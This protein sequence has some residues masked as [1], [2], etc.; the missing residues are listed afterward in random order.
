LSS[1]VLAIVARHDPAR[2]TE[3][4]RRRAKTELPFDA[5][6]V[7]EGAP[8]LFDT[9]VYIDQL[10]GDLP[11]AIVSLISS[12]IIFHATP[13]LAE[14]A[15]TVGALNPTDERTNHTLLPILET[16]ERIPLQR[17]ISPQNETWLE[18]ALIAGILA[19][20]QG[21]AKEARRKFLND[22]L[23]FL[24]A[25]ESGTILIS[26]NARDIDLLLQMRPGVGVLLYQKRT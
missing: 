22:T 13:A 4:L 9:T 23:L 19:R 16:L 3:T 14:I 7:P 21:V 1:D 11:R 5:S 2:W 20:T 26:R 10:K 8:L 15:V 18:A 24:M 25:A 6:R 12:R 17:V